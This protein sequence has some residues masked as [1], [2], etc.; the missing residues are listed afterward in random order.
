MQ[1]ESAWVH[2]LDREAIGGIE[3]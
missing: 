1:S 3:L 2:I